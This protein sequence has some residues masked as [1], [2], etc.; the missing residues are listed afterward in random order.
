MT[1]TPKDDVTIATVDTAGST[2]A[3]RPKANVEAALPESK[4][5]GAATRAAVLAFAKPSKPPT[6]PVPKLAPE[7]NPMGLW[8]PTD[9]EM[10][11]TTERL[12]QGL[13]EER[14]GAIPGPDEQVNVAI[15]EIVR[16]RNDNL[17]LQRRNDS[18]LNERNA[19]VGNAV[20]WKARSEQLKKLYS[21]PSR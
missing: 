21:K 5:E 14:L 20:Y 9:E 8:A 1:S 19:A 17:L 11:A 4:D 6:P 7:V 10:A 16:L 12:L 13:F 3:M 18:L 15:A 2:D